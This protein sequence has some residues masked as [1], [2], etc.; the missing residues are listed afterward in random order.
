VILDPDAFRSNVLKYTT[1]AFGVLPKL[2]RPTIL[3]AGCGTGVPTIRLAE[4]C[5]GIVVA[6]DTDQISLGRLAEKLV[7]KGLSDRVMLVNCP[8]EKMPFDKE[9][10]DVVWAEGSISHLGF[11][12]AEEI[13]GQYLKSGG[14][15][16]LHD[17]ANSYLE[18]LHTVES[19]GFSLLGFFLLSDRVWWD[20]YYKPLESALARADSVR[21]PHQLDAI[22][23]ELE[24]FRIE[25][26]RFRSAFFIMRKG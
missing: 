2:D 3:D 10:F 8:I 15:L 17:D 9:T 12:A 4:L 20:E 1:L 23:K 5:D 7:Q 21:P 19:L 18:K 26:N 24:Q 22:L 6:L 16:V 14:F 13:L 11:K 25:P